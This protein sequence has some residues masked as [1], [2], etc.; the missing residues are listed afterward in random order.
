MRDI[1]YEESKNP[2]NLK[3]Q[4]IAYYVYAALM[5]GMIIAS[6]ITF[7]IWFF[8]GFWFPLVFSILNAILFAF[9]KTK[10]Y[11]CVD[12]IFVTGSTRIVKVINYKRRKKII[13][14]EANEVLQVGKITSESFEKL[15]AMPNIKKV[16]GTPNK[17]LTEG[18]YVHVLQNEQH[19]LVLLECKETYLQHLV[20]FT[21]RKVIEK[22]YK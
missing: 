3:A 12:C 7:F 19:Y 6:V 11:Y 20:A 21:G 1:L 22:D 17:Y 18:F 13:V 15:Q 9:V 10:V 16:Y 4:K 14:F 2:D 5:W 8:S